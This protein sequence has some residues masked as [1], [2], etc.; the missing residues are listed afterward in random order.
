MPP[1]QSM[2]SRAT[3]RFAAPRPPVPRRAPPTGAL[4][5][6]GL[7]FGL[8]LAGAAAVAA[9]GV[10]DRPLKVVVTTKPVHSLVAGVLAG[11]ADPVLL[12]EG[13]AS[14][15]TF[16]MK[17]SAARAAQDA[18]VLVRVSTAVEPFSDRL[19]A[20][21]PA[22]VTVVT[23]ADTPGLTVLDQRRG[24]A[25]EA[26]E[27]AHEHG[28]GAGADHGHGQDHGQADHAAAHETDGHGHEHAHGAPEGPEHG[29]GP[30]HG[31]TEGKAGAD[32]TAP[33]H[34]STL[35]RDGHIWLDPDNARRMVAHLVAVFSRARPEKAE[36]IAANGAA[37]AR[38][39]EA[40]TT[41]IDA[42]MRPLRGKPFIVFHDAT[43]YFEHRFGLSAQGA[44]TVSPEVQPSARRLS[45]LRRR[46]A[47]AG[48]P[49][50]FAEPQFQGGVVAAVVE[51]TSA[52]AGII[53]PEGAQ[54][55]PGPDLYDQLMRNLAAAMTQ[56][57][58]R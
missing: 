47:E 46:I 27:H 52:R 6:C 51:G 50:V 20:A 9:A 55:T 28:N 12:V 1:P 11:I 41:D 2:P 43:Q 30:E 39:L 32:R 24:A 15:H 21:L 42:A 8:G 38:R 40:L 3:P 31:A 18:A 16:V 48:A 26:H 23:L 35:P 22:T 49:C 10:E 33:A 25:F 5:A 14:P 36:R 37:L 57:L 29:T 45:A 56:C 58:A 53:D 19:V 17:P 54:L 44:I 4:V 7:A 13:Q 34:R